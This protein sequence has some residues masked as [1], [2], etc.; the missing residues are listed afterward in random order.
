MCSGN[1]LCEVVGPLRE[2]LQMFLINIIYLRNVVG[3]Q[4][5]FFFKY[6]H[7]EKVLMS[8][9]SVQSNLIYLGFL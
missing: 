9:N 7:I 4:V 2:K 3:S 1:I 8:S 5:D 6:F